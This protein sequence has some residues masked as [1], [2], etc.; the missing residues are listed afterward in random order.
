MLFNYLKTFSVVLLAICDAK[1]NF[2][3]VDIGA[4][5]GQSDGGVLNNSSFGNRLDSNGI[6]FP[7]PIPLPGLSSTFPYFIIANAAFPLKKQIQKPYGGRNLFDVKTNYKTKLNSVRKVIENTFGILV[8]TWRLFMKPIEADP[9]H[10]DM[11]I[12]AA[13]VLH[14]FIK[15]YNDMNTDIF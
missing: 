10:V 3:Y 15:S 11:F 8:K 6:N 14:N 13:I 12:K 4:Y 2:V 5:G 1:K 7:Q 9:C